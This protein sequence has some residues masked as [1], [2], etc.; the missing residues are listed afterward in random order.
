MNP[1]ATIGAINWNTC[2]T[3]SASD[4]EPKVIKV[5][6]SRF[7]D[8]LTKASGCYS[9]IVK[10]FLKYENIH[11]NHKCKDLSK[12]V[13]ISFRF[14]RTENDGRIPVILFSVII[15]SD[16]ELNTWIGTLNIIRDMLMNQG[17]Q[18][19]VDTKVV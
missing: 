3:V 10:Y 19:V 1:V 17:Y 16:S 13:Q 7:V 2:L 14:Y 12:C 18:K 9:E 5:W 8:L 4:H 11:L 15:V 6:Q